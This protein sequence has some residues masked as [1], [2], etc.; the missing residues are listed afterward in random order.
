MV[1]FELDA[2]IKEPKSLPF[3]VKGNAIAQ[4]LRLS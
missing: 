1:D 2:N 4:K 3:G